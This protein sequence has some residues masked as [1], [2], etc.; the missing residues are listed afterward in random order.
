MAQSRQ[1][2]PPPPPP[3]SPAFE[4]SL[5]L[6]LPPLTPLQFDPLAFVTLNFPHGGASSASSYG[7]LLTQ[8]TRAVTASIS[9]RASAQQADSTEDHVQVRT[10]IGQVVEVCLE[11]L[12]SVKVMK[13]LEDESS[14]RRE[15]AAARSREKEGSERKSTTPTTPKTPPSA[16]STSSS[17][18]SSSS[19][20]AS[21]GG[22]ASSAAAGSFTADFQAL[23]SLRLHLV[24]TIR[25]LRSLSLLIAAIDSLPLLFPTRDYPA[26]S[27]LLS[28]ITR[29]QSALA[30][31]SSLP[32]LSALSSHRT[33]H[34]L[35]L[36]RLI[37][38]DL[39]LTLPKLPADA[40]IDA[41]ALRV[42][43]LDQYIPSVR[44][45][46][47]QWFSQ[48]RLQPF[49]SKCSTTATATGATSPPSPAS[50]S[51]PAARFSS[52]T[53]V[54]DMYKMLYTELS[55]YSIDSYDRIFPPHWHTPS[56]L[57]RLYTQYA[58][59]HIQT[60]LADHAERGERLDLYKPLQATQA[61]EVYLSREVEIELEERDG[62]TVPKWRWQGLISSAFDPYIHS[63]VVQEQDRFS[64]A[65][66]KLDK[67]EAW[68]PSEV[69]E[70]SELGRLSGFDKLL[71]VIDKSVE[72]YSKLIHNETMFG[73]VKE[74]RR[75]VLDYLKLLERH[76]PHVGGSSSASS[77]ASPSSAQSAHSHPP[78]SSAASNSLAVGG[79]GGSGT[80]I[81][82]SKQEVSSIILIVHTADYALTRLP[83]LTESCKR[84][85]EEEYAQYVSFAAAQEKVAKVHTKATLTLSLALCNKLD[86]SVLSS[87]REAKRDMLG[88]A[89][90]E[91]AYVKQL[92][93]LIRRE[94]NKLTGLTCYPATLHAFLSKFL[95]LYVQRV[96]VGVISDVWADQLLVDTQTLR[97]YLETL[98]GIKRDAAAHSRKGK[99]K[100]A[101]EEKE[102]DKSAT[103]VVAAVEERREQKEQSGQQA[104]I[105]FSA[106]APSLLLQELSKDDI[107]QAS[108]GA[109]DTVV[110]TN[111]AAT[112]P[113]SAAASPTHSLTSSLSSSPIIAPTAPP[114]SSLPLSASSNTLSL[115][116]APTTAASAATA[117][118]S[119]QPSV[120]P[121]DPYLLLISHHLL[122]LERMLRVMSSPS[123][124]LIATF[125]KVWPKGQ[126]ALLLEMMDLRGLTSR[127]Q[128]RLVKV[129]NASVGEK[130]SKRVE[131]VQ[132]DFMTNLFGDIKK[133]IQ[134]N[135]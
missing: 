52:I 70:G 100:G 58:L 28:Y 54:E 2:S 104:Q 123:P 66:D 69:A 53:Q 133:S 32:L 3:F 59:Q 77:A 92:V 14:N 62:A 109:A 43:L 72:K 103:H 19:S 97:G 135:L 42:G 17:S 22:S 80:S 30:S 129:W 124:S 85:V 40:D 90:E 10:G 25:S 131:W 55:D 89:G 44:E 38:Q 106:T 56:H 127:D 119:A 128:E 107:K 82:L 96:K 39:Y 79:V 116:A 27:K 13:E 115:S 12:E 37:L 35:S 110:I 101:T 122:P 23:D 48:C 73:L 118:S 75:A 26:L 102:K 50:P 7:G 16:T 31:Y 87:I 5:L 49:L 86:S 33:T 120:Q 134:T 9:K 76:I 113:S 11:L 24:A 108:S 93:L 8:V 121:S 57:C 117:D 83:S 91:S 20:S 112:A 41:I 4:A 36:Q 125:R 78:S 88:H 67:E 47:I 68:L 98:P 132:K 63:F 94:I 29:L 34:L 45:E 1:T 21:S 114:A 46:L 126:S 99:K 81:I 105:D 64:R 111:T 65:L 74:Y 18:S 95:V 15:Q 61:V 51:S 60:M 84:A 130:S 71:S 6:P